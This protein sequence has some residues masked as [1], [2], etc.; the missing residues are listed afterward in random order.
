MLVVDEPGERRPRPGRLQQA[1][2]ASGAA[3][4]AGVV[5][6]EGDPHAVAHG[7]ALLQQ[8]GRRDARRDAAAL[9][10]CGDHP[11]DRS[12]LVEGPERTDG[13]GAHLGGA[14]VG[15]LEQQGECSLRCEQAERLGDVGAH[16][17]VAMVGRGDDERCQAARVGDGAQSIGCLAGDAAEHEEDRATDVAPLLGVEGAHAAEQLVHLVVLGDAGFEH[18]RPQ[19]QVQIRAPP[20]PAVAQ[21]PLHH[22]GGQHADDHEGGDEEQRLEQSRRQQRGHPSAAVTRA[23]SARGLKGLVT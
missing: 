21:A 18:E 15:E 7:G 23:S 14:V 10:E 16:D 3:A 2:D 22:E 17:G 13:D 5:V 6:L 9:R 8:R 11:V 19:P 1:G 4:D 20:L 12:W